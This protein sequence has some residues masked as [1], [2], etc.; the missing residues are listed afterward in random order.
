[1]SKF[2]KDVVLLGSHYIRLK[3]DTKILSYFMVIVSV[4]LSGAPS[5]RIWSFP[6]SVFS[7]I[8]FVFS[9]SF[10]P[11]LAFSLSFFFLVTSIHLLLIKTK[12]KKGKKETRSRNLKTSFGVVHVSRISCYGDCGM[13]KCNFNDRF[14]AG[15]AAYIRTHLRTYTVVEK[16]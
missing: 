9:L 13:W 4:I 16:F 10:F 7:R 6:F 15:E 12:G 1:M 5:I 14:Y 3:R 11:F 8:K 2:E